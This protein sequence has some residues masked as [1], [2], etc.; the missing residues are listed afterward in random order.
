MDIKFPSKMTNGFQHNIFTCIYTPQLAWN[1]LDCFPLNLG[2][3][4]RDLKGT[5]VDEIRAKF[6]GLDITGVGTRPG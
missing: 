5:A 2:H 4:V 3:T 1:L 6:A